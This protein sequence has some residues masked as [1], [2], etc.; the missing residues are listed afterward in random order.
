MLLALTR[1]YSSGKSGPPEQLAFDLDSIMPP[2][3]DLPELWMADDIYVTALKEGA[4]RLLRFREDNR[5][6]WKSARYSPKELADYFSMWANT[7]PHG[8][9][10]VIGIENNGDIT[11]C[12]NVG[13]DKVSEFEQ[14]G[15]TQ[16]SDARF[17]VRRIGAKRAD[18]S[19]DFLLLIRVYYR[20]DKLVETVRGDAF[21]RIGKTKRQLSESEKR[22]IRI[23]KGQ[24]EYE[25][26][27]V[28]LEYPADFDELL[29]RE[30]CD[31]YRDKRGL[32][33]AQTREQLLCL[34]HLGTM[35]NGTFAPNLACAL[36]FAIDPRSVTPGARI[37]FMRYDGTEE[38]TG[39]QYNVV[40]DVFV[41]GPVP[42]VIQETESVVAGQI[43]DFTRL[44]RDGKF[45]TR[46]E[47][48][49]DAWLE[50]VV[51]A[52]AHRSYNLQNMMIYVKMF[53][54][55]RVVESPGG[56]PPP[57]TPENIYETHNPRNPHLMNALFYFGRVKCAHEG[58][59]RMRDEMLE[60]EL[61]APEF[62][63]KEVGTHQVHVILRNNIEARKEFVEAGALKLI[64]EAVYE[65][66]D[67][68]EKQLINFVTERGYI[69]V[70]DASRL[71]RRDWGA[72]KKIL[73]ALAKKKILVRQSRTNKP[74]DPSARYL[75]RR[76]QL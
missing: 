24:I 16:C 15:P 36:L 7:Q 17:D 68:S 43:R 9:L 26:E 28:N 56:F 76:R 71:L 55:R 21:V 32:S 47:Y 59:R 63:Q 2:R 65:K 54:D 10:I 3:S 44:G 70:S 61:P 67:Q 42:V 41:D 23:N 62:T 52:C 22:E 6:E 33:G 14:V 11:G 75:L 30:F 46:P 39:K 64:G 34:N 69:N 19:S 48:P 58:T 60:A 38:K 31:Q 50:A 73:E 27:P 40:K 20:P 1:A 37:R 4:E 35:R 25:K 13:S 49:Q 45:Y 74:R 5:V 51:N 53:D 29:I 8:G 18:G 12:L 72:A 66:L 57:V